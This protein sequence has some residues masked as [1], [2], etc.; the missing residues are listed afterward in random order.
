MVS[1]IYGYRRIIL[2]SHCNIQLFLLW[3]TQT[4]GRHD[5][6]IAHYVYSR[7]VSTTF[8]LIDVF[9]QQFTVSNILKYTVFIIVYTISS[10]FHG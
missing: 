5:V 8:S 2:C 1:I 3:N 6:N 10:T 4:A 9:Q 7:I